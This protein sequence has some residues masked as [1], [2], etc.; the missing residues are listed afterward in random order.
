MCGITGILGLAGSLPESKFSR[1]VQGATSALEHRGP[2]DSGT[3][4]DAQAGIA[5]GHRRLSIIDLSRN[6]RQPMV[7]ASGRYVITYNGELYNLSEM[8]AALTAAGVCLR[9]KSDTEVLLETIERQGMV[10][11]LQQSNGM[12]AFALWDRHERTLHFARDRLGQKPLYYGWAGPALAFASELKALLRVPGFTAETDPNAIALLLRF[13]AIPAPH[14]IYRDCWKLL[15]GS[16]LSIPANAIASRCLPEPIIYWSAETAARN[17]I[18]DPI[19]ASP[20]EAVAQLEKVLSSAV[21]ACRLS[22]V[23]LGAFLSGGI[24]SSTIVALLQAQSRRPVKTFTIGFA[25]ADYNEAGDAAAVA[26]HLGTDHTELLVTPADAQAVIPSLPTLYDEP[27]AD[28]S[29]IPTFLVAKLARQQ[30]TVSLSGDGG[31]ELFGGYNRYRWGH[32]LESTIRL[33]PR[34]ARDT[35]ATL[36]RSVPPGAW[37]TLFRVGAGL[38][39]KHLRYTHA[40][41]KLHKLAELV[42]SRDAK[43]L[44]VNLLSQW[45]RPDRALRVAAEPLSPVS[46]PAKWPALEPYVSNMMLLDSIGYLPNDILVKLDRAS[47][48]VSLECRVPF[49]DHHVFEFAWRL[50]LSLKIRQGKPKWPLRQLLSK[51]VPAGLVERPKSGFAVPIGQ[52]LREDLRDWAE[53]LLSE[54]RLREGGIF[55]P[56]TIRETWRQHLSG[57]RNWQHQLW[58]VLMFEAWREQAGRA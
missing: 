16:I 11:A 36:V 20:D 48:G 52:W 34:F 24:D 50:P 25:E 7:S 57:S 54:K 13:G 43:S 42:A 17:A 33:M 32:Q 12:F 31:D 3:W 44:Y 41:D 29:Q 53:S 15:P 18:D 39:P 10:R 30:V 21:Q 5:L 40:G 26:K 4:L 45:Q 28:S 14:S 8:R 55:I 37:D 23:P 9:T 35:L 6:A 58:T 2:D 1:H 46:D 47:M 22:D 19:D 56:E 27:F 38:L 51:Y 49:L